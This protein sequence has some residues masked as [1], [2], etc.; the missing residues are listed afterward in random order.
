MH[1]SNPP[2][3]TAEASQPQVHTAITLPLTTA[4]LERVHS[5]V[6]RPEKHPGSWLSHISDE[7]RLYFRFTGQRLLGLLLQYNSRLDDGEA[8][9][10]EASHLAQGYGQICCKAGMTITDTVQAFLTFQSSILETIHSTRSLSGTVDPDGIRLY[11]RT[12]HF[13]DTL[14]L[15]TVESYSQAV[16]HNDSRGEEADPIHSHP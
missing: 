14:L 5:R 1:R 15:A 16:P 12:T 7:Q 13:F 3:G 6:P 9:L 2:L 11:R 4:P 10:D 8:F